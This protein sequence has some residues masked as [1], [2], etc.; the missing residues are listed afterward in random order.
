MRPS[1]KFE[2]K[3]AGQKGSEAWSSHVENVFDRQRGHRAL[4]PAAIET[5]IGIGS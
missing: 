5:G 2:A 4:Q 1:E 3:A